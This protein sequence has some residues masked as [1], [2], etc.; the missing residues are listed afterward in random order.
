MR[1]TDD[2][3]LKQKYQ[4]TLRSKLVEALL[5]EERNL[6]NIACICDA[7]SADA[8]FNAWMS[9]MERKISLDEGF[10]LIDEYDRLYEQCTSSLKRFKDTGDNSEFQNSMTEFA[11]RLFSL[12]EAEYKL[13]R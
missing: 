4:L 6:L 11:Q 9:R 5:E 1:P 10:G 2:E 12:M 13:F 7:I 3:W 8:R